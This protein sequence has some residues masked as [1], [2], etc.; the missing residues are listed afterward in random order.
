VQALLGGAPA[1]PVAA[2]AVLRA[3]DMAVEFARAAADQA[4]A[5]AAALHT[6]AACIRRAPER[7]GARERGGG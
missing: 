5:A 7:R 2:A 4:G 1:A 6:A 3:L